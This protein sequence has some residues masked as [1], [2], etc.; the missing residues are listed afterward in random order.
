[1]DVIVIVIEMEVDDEARLVVSVD[2]LVE[3]AKGV[4]NLCGSAGIT[5]LS[6]VGKVIF[7]LSSCLSWVI[8]RF[9]YQEVFFDG[10][11][12]EKPCP[13]KALDIIIAV[14]SPGVFGNP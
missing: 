14:R 8:R 5:S 1:M 13:D 9:F 10:L 6:G 4:D 11:P 12:W 7:A 2:P 3:C